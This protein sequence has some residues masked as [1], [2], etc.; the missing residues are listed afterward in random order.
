M[1]RHLL[2]LA[3]TPFRIGVQLVGPRVMPF[4]YPFEQEPDE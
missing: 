3:L 2:R 1:I 4:A